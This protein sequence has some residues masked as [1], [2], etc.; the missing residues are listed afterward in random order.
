MEKRDLGVGLGGLLTGLA[1]L[2]G[3]LY[4]TG[5]WKAFDPVTNKGS[6]MAE[7]VGIKMPTEGEPQPTPRGAET[8]RTAPSLPGASTSPN[9]GAG[10]LRVKL[11]NLTMHRC[12]GYDC[13]KLATLPSGTKVV[14]LGDLD[15]APGEVWCRVRV[16]TTEGWVSRYYLE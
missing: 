9:R 12:P 7:K 15:S 6:Q 5:G 2:G 8:P 13:E 11:N 10:I 4:Y 16:G 1:L 3:L 14:L